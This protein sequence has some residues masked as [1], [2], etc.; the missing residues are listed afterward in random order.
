VADQERLTGTVELDIADPAARLRVGALA[1]GAAV[2]TV[3]VAWAE[4]G[5]MLPEASVAR[6]RKVWAP[7]LRPVYSC[8]GEQLRKEALSR[9]HSKVVSGLDAMKSKPAE[10]PLV[11]EGPSTIAVLGAPDPDPSGC[12]A[13][14]TENLNPVPTYRRSEPSALMLTTFMM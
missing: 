14:S 7:A 13:G 1:T 4:V 10:A 5:S 12:Q 9:L 8:G 2:S 6:T 3:H 11:P